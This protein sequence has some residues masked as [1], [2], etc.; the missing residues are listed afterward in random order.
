MSNHSDVKH[1]KIEH[2]ATHYEK[3]GDILGDQDLS[4]E[5]KAKALNTWEQDARQ[6]MI[7]SDEGMVGSAE[8]TQPDDHNRLGEVDRAKAKMGKKP[9]H[10]PSH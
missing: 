3:P 7:A 10:K 1:T 4:E 8:G 5:D 6:L 2:P 9:E